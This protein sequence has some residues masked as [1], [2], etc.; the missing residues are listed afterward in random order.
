MK[1][2]VEDAVFDLLPTAF[3]GV[4]VGRG[5]NNCGSNGQIA[6]MLKEAIQRTRDKFALIKPKE[7]PNIQPY[8]RAFEKLG[9]NPNRFPCSVEALSARIAKG[10]SLPD[11]N[12]VVNLVNIYSLNYTLPMGAHDLDATESDIL[13]RFSQTGDKFVPF[14]GEEPEVPDQGELVYASGSNVKTRKWIWRQ[15]EAGKVTKNSRNIFFP[16][17]GFADYNRD[18]V[19]KA[20]EG[21]AADLEQFLGGNVTK[22]Y[23]DKNTRSIL[24]L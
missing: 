14:G 8:R 18:T 7:H 3:F 20:C 15:S 6:V 5:I 16:I 1:F 23:V 12:P 11:I 24:L 2:T 21:L 10:G 4:V 13:V 22:Y 19:V 9:I 17:D